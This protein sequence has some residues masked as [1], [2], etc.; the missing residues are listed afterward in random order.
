M[1]TITIASPHTRHDPLVNNLVR[2]LPEYTIIRVRDKAELSERCL[3]LQQAEKIF[4]P[5]WSWLI[6]EEI[7]SH[8][9]CIV[10]H[11]TDLPY[12]RGGSPLQN[13]IVRGHTQTQLSALRC[14]DV[15][16]G[17]PVYLK[18]P[19][20]LD[21]TAEQIL[22]R[23]AAITEDLIVEICEKSPQPGPQEGQIVQFRRR[24]KDDGDIARLDDPRE[25]FNH[26][27]MLDA[28]GYPPAFIEKGKLRLEFSNAELLDD[29]VQAMVTIRKSEDE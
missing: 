23:A 20:S 17:G 11:M 15:L 29:K 19:L 27:R 5:H 24:Q 14:T 25:I 6:P 9:E 3:A 28:D 1:T 26:I 10:F 2:R 8:H 4:F 16:D 12:G 21:G 13:L 22:M 7:F 18:R